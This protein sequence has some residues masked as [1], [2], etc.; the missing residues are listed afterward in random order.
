[1]ATDHTASIIH[2]H[3]PQP[4]A[5]RALTG[6][7]RAKAYR[8]RK[9]QKAAPAEAGI[10]MAP[11]DAI[12][13]TIPTPVTLALSIEDVTPVTVTPVTPSREPVT[14]SLVTPVTPVTPVT[15]PSRCETG[16]A[17]ISQNAPPVSQ[18][19]VLD[20]RRHSHPIGP[21][22]LVA[23]AFGLAGVGVTMNG[24]F[25]RSLGSSDIAG[26]LFLAIGVAAD[27]V[28]L[29]LPSC[30][31]RSWERRQRG[32][33]LAGWLVW[34]MTFAFAVTA[35][36]GFASVNI[37]D[38]TTARAGRS[39]PAIVAAKADLADAMAARDRECAGG[40]GKNCRARED[41]VGDRRRV[42]DAAMHDVVQTA[43]P[44]TEAAIKIVAWLSVGT[45]KPTGDDFAMLRLML[46][47]I[48]P[49]IGGVLLMVSR[50]GR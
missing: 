7:E 47:A 39:T 13:E 10:P 32:A 25:A 1:M 29:A 41:V 42:L 23:A 44:Q 2:L 27:V 21:A 16:A 28:A 3:Q 34:L 43:D 30:A 33:A 45:L 8:D 46:L 50:A 9:R 22:L 5:P 18:N 49:Q 20:I 36:I 38:V 12:T 26:W 6:A 17:L 14:P 19:A 48:L 35:G 37:A 24:W 11:A 40:I 31:A 15:A 4:T